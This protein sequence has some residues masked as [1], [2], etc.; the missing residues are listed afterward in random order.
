M[1]AYQQ[2][3]GRHGHL[4][5]FRFDA[6]G[7][8]T[9]WILKDQYCDN[10]RCTCK[11]ASIALQAEGEP[12]RC[13]RFMMGLVECTLS[14]CPN[15]DESLLAIAREFASRP[16]VHRLLW[17]RRSI[18]R[19]WALSRWRH[20]GQA[21]LRAGAG[22][23]A[24]DEFDPLGEQHAIPFKSGGS[25]WGA[26]DQYCVNPACSCST[27]ILHFT[28]YT[29]A[30]VAHHP[31]FV[32]RLDLIDGTLVDADSSEPLPP[33]QRRV[34]ADFQDEIDPWR[35]ELGLRRTLI[36]R[37]AALRMTAPPLIE[38]VAPAQRNAPCPCGSGRKYKKCCGGRSTGGRSTSGSAW[39]S[40]GC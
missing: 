33:D 15:L 36:R 13:I 39:S 26:I 17:R 27:V 4:R 21:G 10:P 16:E 22:C 37:I 1:K 19:A 5:T 2:A 25:D 7:R 14:H 40:I 28:R 6:E 9:H 35:D 3:A 32:A 20:H 30:V 18:V 8:A 29:S 34:V 38:I 12:D 11:D 23:C 24:L 31:Q